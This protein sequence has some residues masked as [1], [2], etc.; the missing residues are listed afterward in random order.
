[1]KGKLHV[2]HPDTVTDDINDHDEFEIDVGDPL[3]AYEFAVAKLWREDFIPGTVK[4]ML[5]N[6]LGEILASEDKH[7]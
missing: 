1:M 2:F 4:W 7:N 6:E 5:Y 3:F